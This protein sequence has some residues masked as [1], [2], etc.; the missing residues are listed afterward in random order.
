VVGIE[1]R[2][3]RLVRQRIGLAARQRQLS[4]EVALDAL[5]LC[6]R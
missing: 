2:E 1:E 4:L 6:G 5:E 3:E